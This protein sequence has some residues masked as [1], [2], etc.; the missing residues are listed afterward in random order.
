MNGTTAATIPI[1]DANGRMQAADPASGATDKTLVTAN[2]VSQTGDSGPNNLIHKNGNETKT[3]NFGLNGFFNSKMPNY[4]NI[5]IINT[6][7]DNTDNTKTDRHAYLIFADANGNSI[8]R[9]GYTHN[10][11]SRDIKIR[12]YRADG[13]W[14]PDIV[15]GQVTE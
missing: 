11:N 10:L 7:D 2:W 8:A 5:T 13:T 15:L 6:T 9:I 4:G 14:F 1:R 3:G 12:F